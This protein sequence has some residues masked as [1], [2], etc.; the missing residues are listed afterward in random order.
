[1]L[2]SGYVIKRRARRA[3]CSPN[4][5]NIAEELAEAKWRLV[6][7]EKDVAEVA[8]EQLLRSWPALDG[9]LKRR[10]EFLIWK[11]YLEDERKFYDETPASAKTAALL[12]GRRL[13]VARDLLKMQADDLA[14]EERKYISDSVVEEKKQIEDRRQAK[15]ARA[16]TEVARLTVAGMT[17][18]FATLVLEHLF[19][20][21][22]WH[23]LLS[24]GPVAIVSLV[25]LAFLIV[26]VLFLPQTYEI[27]DWLTLA[28]LEMNSLLRAWGGG[29]ESRKNV[30]K[31][32]AEWL[33]MIPDTDDPAPLA[34]AYKNF[35]D[36]IQ[37]D[38]KSGGSQ[39]AAMGKA[40]MTAFLLREIYEGNVK[41]AQLKIFNEVAS[42]GKPYIAPGIR[43]IVGYDRFDVTDV[44]NNGFPP[45]AGVGWF[46]LRLTVKL[47]RYPRNIVMI[48]ADKTVAHNRTVI[49]E[50]A[51]SVVEGIAV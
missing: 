43:Q 31:E 20:M 9:W 33:S 34:E 13:E 40:R 47:N 11:S 19:D 22:W 6:T 23:D 14:P 41:N 35:F 39:G 29:Y 49:Y 2:R 15:N 38:L 3:E 30:V 4:E 27:A 36:L 1:M 16:R 26:L 21:S 24:Y 5:W 28:E 10:W 51:S 7:L 37:E 50:L 12:T 8:H 48:R 44:K 18:A 25:L 46:P 17:S 42:G 32:R 45:D